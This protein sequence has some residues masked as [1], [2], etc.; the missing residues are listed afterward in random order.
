MEEASW[1]PYAVLDEIGGIDL[2]IPQFRRALD[3]LLRS[4]LPIL[5][6]VKSMEASEQ[7]RQ[8]LGPGERFTAFSEQLFAFLEEDPNTE[9]LMITN[10]A[11][12]EAGGAVEIWIDEYAGLPGT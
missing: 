7:M 11:E 1:Y 3:E 4:E 10:D 2:I 8:M 6:A 5:G 9:L 12:E